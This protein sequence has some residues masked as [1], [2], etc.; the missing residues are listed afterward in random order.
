VQTDVHHTNLE[1]VELSR[2]EGHQL[3]DERVQELLG[4][5]SDE[6]LRRWDAGELDDL[7]ESALIELSLMIPLVRQDDSK[8]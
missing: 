5:G 1:I 7:E 4:I 3:F 8:A 2:N 6:F